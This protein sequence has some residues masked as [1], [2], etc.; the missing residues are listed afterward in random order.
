MALKVGIREFRDKLATYLLES[1]EPMAI[2]RQGHIVRYYDP[3]RRKRSETER[4]MLKEAASCLQQSLAAAGL[5]EEEIMED[6]RH[7]CNGEVEPGTN[8]EA[9]INE[10]AGD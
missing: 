4:A 7:W 10:R 1:E 9:G 2:T 6:F 8:G 3:A 5:S